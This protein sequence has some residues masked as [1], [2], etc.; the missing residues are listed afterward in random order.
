MYSP[1]GLTLAL[2]TQR[3]HK[4]V[5]PISDALSVVVPGAAAAWVDTIKRYGKLPLA[6]V[7]EPAIQLADE[8]WPVG[9]VTAHQWANCEWQ[10]SWHS[11]VG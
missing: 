9:P 2:V 10:V 6:K 1:A 3:G 8:G 5:I 7:L 4:G 11:P